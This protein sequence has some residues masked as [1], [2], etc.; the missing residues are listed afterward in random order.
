MA[1]YKY[2]TGGIELSH[3]LVDYLRNEGKEAFIFYISLTTNKMVTDD[4]QVTEAYKKYNITVANYIE[5]EPINVV[6]I[7]EAFIKMIPC[8]KKAQICIWWMSVENALFWNGNFG[9]LYRHANGWR[10]KANL[11]KKQFGRLVKL[12]KS[13]WKITCKFF[14]HE[15]Y[16]PTNPFP[17]NYSMAKLLKEDYRLYH[18]YQATYIQQFLYS[19]RFD[20]ILRLTDYINPEIL[21]NI[22]GSVRKE[23]IILYNPAKGLYYTKKLMK[24]MQ[25]YRFIPLQGFT[26]DQLNHLFDKAKLYIDFGPFPGKDRLPREAAI[27]NCCVITGRFEASGFFEDVPVYGK[28]KFDMLHANYYEIKHR[29][30]E[31]FA[32]YENCIKD[33]AY[34]RESILMEQTNFHQ[35]VKNIFG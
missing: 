5:D 1:P 30:D 3:Q 12:N 23:N 19:Q 25:G 16:E 7:P 13:V 20:R 35:E 8:F 15:Y 28:Y 32:N 21:K 2:A 31:V 11:I 33:F 29:I 34:M 26:R 6:V 17:N 18:F 24:V 27:H 14:G 9:D 4:N 10:Q 22:N